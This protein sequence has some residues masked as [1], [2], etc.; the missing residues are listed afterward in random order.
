MLSPFADKWLA[1]THKQ[2]K[3][4]KEW[5]GCVGKSIFDKCRQAILFEELLLKPVGYC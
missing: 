3:N 2:V 1:C 5:N 4:I